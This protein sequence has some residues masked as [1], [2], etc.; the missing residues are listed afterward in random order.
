MTTIFYFFFPA[1]GIVEDPNPYLTRRII[2]DNNTD[3]LIVNN[4]T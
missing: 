2:I 1:I 3:R 4:T